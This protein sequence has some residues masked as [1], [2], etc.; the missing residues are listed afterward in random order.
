MASPTRREI[1]DEKLS[2]TQWMDNHYGRI[3]PGAYNVLSEMVFRSE[4]RLRKMDGRG[5]NFI[6]PSMLDAHGMTPEDLKTCTDE[7]VRMRIVREPQAGHFELEDE[8]VWKQK[9]RKWYSPVKWLTWSIWGIARITRLIV[10]WCGDCS[11]AVIRTLRSPS[12]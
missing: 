7:L 3:S 10:T 11:D 2:R 5:M 9:Y 6:A 12:P 1:E 4:L 8:K